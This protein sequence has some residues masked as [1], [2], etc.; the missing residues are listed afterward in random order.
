MPRVPW[1][2]VAKIYSGGNIRNIR[3]ADPRDDFYLS[4]LVYWPVRQIALFSNSAITKISIEDIF[5]A[6]ELGALRSRSFNTSRHLKMRVS[7]SLVECMGDNSTINRYI[8]IG[9]RCA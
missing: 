5:D 6:P 2:V 4:E 1:G 8:L 9:L 7:K 3:I